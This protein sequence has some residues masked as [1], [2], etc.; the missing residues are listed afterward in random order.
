MFMVDLYGF[1]YHHQ[2][3]HHFEH[4]IV[5][6]PFHKQRYLLSWSFSTASHG[7]TTRGWKGL[8]FLCSVAS[9]EYTCI[10]TSTVLQLCLHSR[11]IV[12][13]LAWFW[14]VASNNIHWS[15][16][17]NLIKHYSS[18]M[19]WFILS[20]LNYAHLIS[21]SNSLL[22]NA[23]VQ[24]HPWLVEQLLGCSSTATRLYMWLFISTLSIIDVRTWIWLLVVDNYQPSLSDYQ[25]ITT[26]ML[27]HDRW[28]LWS[29]VK[30]L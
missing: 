21:L 28:Q 11:S 13:H 8:F 22:W 17:I 16:I 24:G 1:N 6:W 23:V 12:N 14:V 19:F 25:V 26:I 2:T 15:W 9:L 10:A 30:T 4:D 5:E 27:N 29:P 7:V 20:I 3:K 18:D